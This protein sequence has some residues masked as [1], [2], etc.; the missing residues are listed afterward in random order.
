VANGINYWCRNIQL[1]FTAVS[2]GCGI[3]LMLMPFVHH[4]ILQA[5]LHTTDDAGSIWITSFLTNITGGSMTERDS[6]I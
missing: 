5:K 6:V 4:L 2:L 1:V 3:L